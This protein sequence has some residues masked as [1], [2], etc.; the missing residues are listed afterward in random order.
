MILLSDKRQYQKKSQ[1][2]VG[3]TRSFVLRAKG[4]DSLIQTF[5]LLI[6]CGELVTEVS[7]DFLEIRCV[8]F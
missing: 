1:N 3:R 4:A 5:F 2:T 6:S 7:Y 8:F